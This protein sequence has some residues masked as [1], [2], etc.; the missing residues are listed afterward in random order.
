MSIKTTLSKLI[1]AANSQALAH[2]SACIPPGRY[3]FFA[4]KLIDAVQA[5]LDGYN[6]QHNELIKKHGVPGEKGT[7][8]LAGATPENV[9][10]FFTAENELTATEVTIPYQPI[11]YVKLGKEADEKLTIN[12]IRAMGPLLVE[13]DE[14]APAPAAEPP[15]PAA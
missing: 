1:L 14:P 9:E 3:K 7:I 5:E 10:A 15:K 11:E 13:G 8:T 2:V 12:D 6:K 4:A